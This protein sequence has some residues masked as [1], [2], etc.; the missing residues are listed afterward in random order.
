MPV[1]RL[2]QPTQKERTGPQ[3]C[4]KCMT[5]AEVEIVA[6]IAAVVSFARCWL[7]RLKAQVVCNK[8]TQETSHNTP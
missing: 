1:K 8:V 4:V 2:T 6:A 5:A 3:V 7:I